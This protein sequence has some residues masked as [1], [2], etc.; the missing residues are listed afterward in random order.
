M[1]DVGHLAATEDGT[2]DLRIAVDV[3]DG[4][5]HTAKIILEILFGITT[6]SA[7]DITRFFDFRQEV[8]TIVD[9]VA[10]EAARNNNLGQAMVKGI[11]HF[12]FVRAVL[13]GIKI[14]INTHTCEGDHA[15]AVEV[16]QNAAA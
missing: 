3:D 11:V 12:C 4:I 14:A 8:T 1:A 9:F 10:N 16:A 5:G 7:I 13:K 2:V 6:A 15:A